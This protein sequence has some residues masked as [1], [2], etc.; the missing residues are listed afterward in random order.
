MSLKKKIVTYLL[1]IGLIPLLCLAAFTYF[2]ANASLKEASFSKLGQA[3]ELK[4]QAVESYF[5]GIKNQ[6]ITFSENKMVVDASSQLK[7][8]FKSYLEES[9]A[10]EAELQEMRSSVTSYYNDQFGAEYKSQN[11]VAADTQ[12]VLGGIEDVTIALQYNYISNNANPLGSKHMLDEAADASAYSLEH[13]KVHPVIRSYLEKFGYYDIFLVDS[14]TGHIFYSVFKELDYATSLMTGPFKDSGIAEAFRL[15][16]N[17]NTKDSYHLVDYDNYW[18]SYEA[19]AS[20][21]SSPIF[22]KNNRKIAVAIFQMPLD[23]LNSIMSERSGLGETGESILVGRD[24]LPRSNSFI[25]EKNR[26]VI[27]AYKNK[28]LGAISS[29]E[30]NLSLEGKSGEGLSTNYLGNSSIISY[31]PVDVLG[32]KWS[33][34]AQIDQ[35]EAFESVYHLSYFIVAVVIFSIIIISL[36]GVLVANYVSNPISEASSSLSKF[37]DVIRTSSQDLSRSSSMLSGLASSQASSITETAASLEQVSAMVKNNSEQSHLSVTNSKEVF[38]LASKGTESI[39]RMQDAINTILQSN[40][41]IKKLVEIIAQIG[42]KTEIIDEI[43]FQTKLLSFNAAVEAERA[44]E[45]GR[46]FAVVAQEVSNLALNSGKASAE[47]ASIVKSSISDAEQIT[48]D[49]QKKVENGVEITR[50]VSKILTSIEKSAKDLSERATQISSASKEQSSGVDQINL[51]IAQLDTDTQQNTE[52]ANDNASAAVQLQQMVTEIEK[53][54]SSLN[55]FVNSSN[56]LQTPPLSGGP[57]PPTDQKQVFELQAFRDKNK[58]QKN[59]SS[60]KLGAR[61]VGQDTNDSNSGGWE[62]I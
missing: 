4:K 22:N 28:K 31:G 59:A 48:T 6:I 37:T 5:E 1:L 60:P 30:V 36:L 51:A 27:S 10:D 26:N 61:A 29:Q 52:A 35:D 12:A 8:Q 56:K 39:H 23:R 53:T 16:N 46:G 14:E 57:K 19:P 34:L 15:A 7:S 55:S 11:G 62:S 2:L 50:E 9:Y 13:A 44:G 18:P 21:I 54:I 42:E 33:L 58:D 24:N 17:S 40:E 47:I 43:V 3:R 32:L 45:H 49:N 41:D 38:E 25:D 20:F